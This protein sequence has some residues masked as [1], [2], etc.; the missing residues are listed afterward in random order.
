M[1]ILLVEDDRQI[2]ENIAEYLRDQSFAVDI[3]FDGIDGYNAAK[4][5]TPYDLILLDRMLPGKDGATICRE[6]RLAGCKTPI[7]MVTAMDSVESK[8]EWLDFWA[9][10]YIVKP[11]AL[12]ELFARINAHIRRQHDNL[13]DGTK[14]RIKDLILDTKTKQVTRGEKNVVLSRKLYQ[15]LELLMRNQWT[16]LSKTQIEEHIWEREANL[17]SDVVRSHIQ[18]LRAKIDK[19]FDVP[20]IKTVHGMGYTIENEKR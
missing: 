18:L 8:V 1:K 2:A 17:W 9:D 13:D 10:D 16:V 5:S 6:L 14:L 11:F 4:G 7:I 19:G 3:A 15:L 20:I 12:K